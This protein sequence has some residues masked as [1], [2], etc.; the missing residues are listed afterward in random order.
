M[1]TPGTMPPSEN[2]SHIPWPEGGV[3]GPGWIPPG[4]AIDCSRDAVA[5]VR[6]FLGTFDAEGAQA[7]WNGTDCPRGCM[8]ALAALARYL[9]DRGGA[10]EASAGLLLDDIARQFED[11]ALDVFGVPR[12]ADSTSHPQTPLMRSKRQE[13]G[14]V[15]DG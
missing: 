2:T 3:D 11:S 13:G 1:R 10:D 7:I 6:C 5:L 12:A 8:V 15:S 14:G 4:M 9:L